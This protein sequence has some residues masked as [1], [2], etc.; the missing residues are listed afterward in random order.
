M[1]PETKEA[2]DRYAEQG[3]VPGS[4]LEAVFANDLLCA[5]NYSDA[6]NLRDLKAIA[7]YAWR[8][9]PHRAL[10]SFAEVDDWI[11]QK[12]RERDDES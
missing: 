5:V 3:L 10:G 9:V 2:I 11:A 4:F 1:K 7:R 12:E 6:D 8:K